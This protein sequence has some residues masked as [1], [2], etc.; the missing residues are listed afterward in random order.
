MRSRRGE[1]RSAL[2]GAITD[3]QLVLQ[4]QRL[5]GD[6]ADATW[7]EELREGDQQVDGKDEEVAHGANRTM[8]AS[9]AQDCTA[10]ADSVTLR[11]RHPQVSGSSH[12]RT[13]WATG[14]S[15]KCNMARVGSHHIGSSMSISIGR[16]QPYVCRLPRPVECPP[17]YRR[18]RGT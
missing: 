18:S 16:K 8:T 7:A 5:G 12:R 17:A 14:R 1:I 9:A 6:G 4:Q 3:E 15:T 13:A 10:R 11:I 2:A